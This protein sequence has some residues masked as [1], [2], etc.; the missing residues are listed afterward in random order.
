MRTAKVASRRKLP[1]SC[2]SF[3]DEF[4]IAMELE[5]IL[6]GAG[7]RVLGP[8][9]T[10]STALILLEDSYPNA[11][12]LDVNLGGERVTL[13]ARA[14]M[15]RNIPFV[16]ASACRPFNLANEPLLSSAVNLGKPTSAARLKEMSRLLACSGGSH[17]A[18]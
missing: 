16:V 6:T 8:A 10:V 1:T 2:W 12:V 11:A 13:V 4:L 9:A 17:Q 7:Y 3:E 14:L 18:C 5:A 15:T